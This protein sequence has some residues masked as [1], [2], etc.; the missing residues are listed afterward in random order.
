M[1]LDEKP[2]GNRRAAP[3]AA[4]T[5]YTERIVCARAYDLP[6]RSRSLLSGN[7][8]LVAPYCNPPTA[9]GPQRRHKVTQQQ[10]LFVCK[11]S[12]SQEPMPH[13]LCCEHLLS[14][15]PG[16][17]ARACPSAP[18]P[19]KRLP[20]CS[21]R[22]SSQFQVR[23]ARTHTHC[24]SAPSIQPLAHVRLS[25]A[26]HSLRTFAYRPKGQTPPKSHTLAEKAPLCGPRRSSQAACA[27]LDVLYT[28]IGLL[29]VSS[30]QVFFIS[31]NTPLVLLA[32]MPAHGAVAPAQGAPGLSPGWWQATTGSPELPTM[33]GARLPVFEDV[34]A[35]AATPT[36]SCQQPQEDGDCPASSPGAAG[37]TGSGRP[38]RRER[39]AHLQWTPEQARD[40]QSR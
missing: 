31:F 10:P 28:K 3:A 38:N 34:A 20:R 6:A 37:N 12:I 1:W 15:T 26:L 40:A 32:S 27:W 7:Y 29:Y 35:P 36:P 22:S 18:G 5:R 2:A 4:Y 25:S 19:A 21:T 14:Q 16:C 9:K 23:Y 24:C 13:S 8:E 33:Q 30:R 11:C 39:R 17:T